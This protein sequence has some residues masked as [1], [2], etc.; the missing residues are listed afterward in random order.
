MASAALSKVK[1]KLHV[2]NVKLEAPSWWLKINDKGSRHNKI[3]RRPGV[4]RLP[5]LPVLSAWS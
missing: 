1:P 2:Y 3:K 5:G 4:P